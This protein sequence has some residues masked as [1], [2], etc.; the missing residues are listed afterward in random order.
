MTHNLT[1][2]ES[3]PIHIEL[4]RKLD[5]TLKSYDDKLSRQELL[6]I[7]ATIVGKLVCLQ[8]QILGDSKLKAL[9]SM[10]I[11]AG[12]DMMIGG[13]DNDNGTVQ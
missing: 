2:K 9:I 6:A 5:E 12:I 1:P 13:A 11:Q 10:N 7:A 3:S 4:F 8:D